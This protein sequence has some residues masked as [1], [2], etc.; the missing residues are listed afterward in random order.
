MVQ[1]ARKTKLF[2]NH[3]KTQANCITEI[4]KKYLV[5]KLK[6]F[7]PDNGSSVASVLERMSSQ[8]SFQGRNLGR[9]FNVW[10]QAL[11]EKT[12][13][14]FGLAGAMVPAGMRKTIVCLIKNRLIDVIVSTGAN[15]FHDTC[16]TL[17][18]PH[19]LGTPL[20]ND[21]ELCR[22]KINRIYD[23]YT[24]DTDLNRA[25][26]Y[27]AKFA[28]ELENRPYPTAEFFYR[29]GEKLSKTTSEEGIL[30]AAS[31]SGVPVYCPS[32]A[33]SSI[34][35][36]LVSKFYTDLIYKQDGKSGFIFDVLSDVSDLGRL[37]AAAPQS[38]I[39]FVSGG[40]PKN[41]IQQSE[42]T[43]ELMGLG[44]PGH[45]YAIQFTSDAPHWGG[46]S[47]CTFEEGQSWG[48]IASDCKKVI[49]FCDATIALPLMVTGLAEVKAGAKRPWKP[50]FK[51]GRE[52]QFTF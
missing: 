24:R 34:G 49:V 37:V 27:I 32:V 22:G 30:T 13:L 5:Y 15:L 23:V 26:E 25:D 31:Q 10:R 11:S 8:V 52:V 20:V 17:G 39:I 21:V 1:V 6:P 46:L 16:E 4:Q 3:S 38:G 41:F 43:A 2:A 40:V 18:L 44:K 29:L 7:E 36:T 48:K 50:Q 14:S 19:Y 12:V 9:A 45:K 47:G 33:D 42:I 28:A 51:I 35:I